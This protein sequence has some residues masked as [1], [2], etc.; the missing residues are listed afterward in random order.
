MFAMLRH[1]NSDVEFKYLH[2]FKQINKC[3]KWAGIRCTL[4]KAK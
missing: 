4:A 3:E 1:D 2:V